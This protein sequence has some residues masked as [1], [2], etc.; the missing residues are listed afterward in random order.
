MA[1]SMTKVMYLA[2]IAICA[3]SLQGCGDDTPG[4]KNKAEYKAAASSA[5]EAEE[6]KAADTNTKADATANKAVEKGNGCVEFQAAIKV[7]AANDEMLKKIVDELKQDAACTEDLKSEACKSAIALQT[8]QTTLYMV[9][10]D[11]KFIEWTKMPENGDK[12]DKV[13][14][15][16]LNVQLEAVITPAVTVMQSKLPADA[17]MASVTESPFDRP[18]WLKTQLG[19]LIEGSVEVFCPAYEEEVKEA[20]KIDEPLVDEKID[21]EAA[22]KKADIAAVKEEDK[23]D[24]STTLAPNVAELAAKSAA[25]SD[26]ALSKTP[27]E[28]DAKN[29]ATGTADAVAGSEVSKVERRLTDIQV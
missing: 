18:S 20:V 25:S 16:P 4:G 21:A 6:K 26:P 1:Q 5:V 9:E 10:K 28:A 8:A 17:T 13:K 12:W 11:P 23:K 7:E 2:A 24:K 15:G 27:T 14:A 3:F 22:I 19:Q 29:T